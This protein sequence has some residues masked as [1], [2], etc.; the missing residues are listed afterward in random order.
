MRLTQFGETT[1]PELNGNDDLSQ[2]ARSNLVPLKYGAIDL[3]NSEVVL[4][5]KRINRT[6]VINTD[7]DN[8]MDDLAYESQKGARI[9]KATM[10]D[11]SERQ[12]L[13]K[14]TLFSRGARAEK[15][16]CEQEFG[17]QWTAT[18][19][20]WLLTSHEPI[21]SDHGYESDSG[22]FSD[23]NSVTTSV[24][25]SSVNFTITNASRVRIAKVYFSLK[26]NGTTGEWNN[27]KITNNTN[28]MSIQVNRGITGNSTIIRQF[29]NI[30]CLAKKVYG[31]FSDNSNNAATY[32]LYS[33]TVIGDDQMDWMILEPG[34][35]EF[36]ITSTLVGGSISR[37]IVV[38]W[39]NHYM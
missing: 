6:A 12:L 30:D 16:T 25:T 35:N 38:F 29:I 34:D 32:N 39:S 31:A 19:P 10:R 2:S 11:D 15:Y 8:T 5:Y 22:L 36:T 28:K 4:D 26:T 23:G 3:D 7:F 18:Y 13:A 1:L 27:P 9:L 33:N 37:D 14:M 17:L 21:Y 20:Y 24:T